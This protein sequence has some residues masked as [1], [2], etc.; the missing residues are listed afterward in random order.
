MGPARR[1]LASLTA[2]VRWLAD[3]VSLFG[4]DNL[5]KN[6]WATAAGLSYTP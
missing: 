3:Q 4:K 5:Q 1:R 6:P 2:R